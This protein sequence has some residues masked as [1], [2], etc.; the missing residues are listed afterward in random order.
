MFMREEQQHRPHGEAMSSHQKAR[1][2]GSSLI[3]L[4]AF[5]ALV[6]VLVLAQVLHAEALTVDTWPVT[7]PAVTL[8]GTNQTVSGSTAAWEVDAGGE[9]GGWNLTVA[10]TD[11]T[12]A[13]KT[14]AVANFTIRLLNVDIVLGAGDP[15]L[16]T[17]TQTTFAS[18][19][20]TPLKIASAAVGEGDGQYELTPGFELTVP[21][22]TYTGAY[23]A[24]LTADV[25]VGP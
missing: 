21:A 24:T 23:S 13:A 15:A 6:L 5:A 12:A 11:F 1:V 8:D 25:A 10:S 3:E 16:P 22:E 2:G 20:G 19:S 14:I 7:F 18:L 4:A 17:S 9:A